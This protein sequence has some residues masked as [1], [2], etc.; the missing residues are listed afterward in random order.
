MRKVLTLIGLLFAGGWAMGQLR[1]TEIC[2]RP[3][4]LDPNGKE[5]GWIELTNTSATEEV[6]LSNYALIR[7][8]RGKTDKKGN[9]LSLLPK[10]L[11]PGERFVVYASESYSNFS[12]IGGSGEVEWLGETEPL[13]VYPVKINPKKWPTV[14]LYKGS[15]VIDTFEVPVDLAD[16]KS[17]S[18]GSGKVS[19]ALVASNTPYSYRLV[20]EETWQTGGTGALAVAADREITAVE[21][22]LDV[23]I[24]ADSP[25][26]TETQVVAGNVTRT[27]WDLSSNTDKNTGLTAPAA[28]LQDAADAYTVAFWFKAESLAGTDDESHARVLF[29]YRPKSVADKSGVI[30]VLTS[31]GQIRVQGRNANRTASFDYSTD[32]EADYGDGTWHHV[33]L[34]VGRNAGSAVK[35]WADGVREISA[36]LGFAMAAR[37]DVPI[38]FGQAYDS[39]SWAVFNGAMSDIRLYPRAERRRGRGPLW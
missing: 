16:G 8:N 28:T 29:D 32:S 15:S 38:C 18:P 31:E 3:E 26:F 19:Q 27:A 39:T 34:V 6:D 30:V 9:R 13:M 14:R 35:V 11:Q 33:V 24:S 4:G 12:D 25:A 21:G 5:S 22:A 20:G 37:T 36:S 23:T 1:I 7:F 17:F 10:T 2:P